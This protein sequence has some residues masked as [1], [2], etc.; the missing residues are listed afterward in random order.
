M[1]MANVPDCRDQML[2]HDLGFSSHG[3]FG[4]IWGSFVLC[5]KVAF[6]DLL[7]T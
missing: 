3:R 5:S 1:G 2:L 4:E 6:P 7:I